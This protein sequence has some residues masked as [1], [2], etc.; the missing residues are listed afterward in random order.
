MF[1]FSKGHRNI[2]LNGTQFGSHQH[3]LCNLDMGASIPFSGPIK[4]GNCIL[5][6]MEML[7]VDSSCKKHIQRVIN[8]HMESHLP[9]AYLFIRFCNDI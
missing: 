8:N 1:G 7:I 4:G 9:H 2:S 5:S 6:V 3:F